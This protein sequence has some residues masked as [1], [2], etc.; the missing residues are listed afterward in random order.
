MFSLRVKGWSRLLTCRDELTTGLEGL[1]IKVVALAQHVGHIHGG[2][3]EVHG[4]DGG[5]EYHV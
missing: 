3:A 1:V 4:G 5:L 2:V